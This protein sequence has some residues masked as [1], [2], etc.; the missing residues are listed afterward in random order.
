MG[1]RKKK[2]LIHG[3]AIMRGG[4][5]GPAPKDFFKSKFTAIKKEHFGVFLKPLKTLMQGK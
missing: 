4:G 2:S 1:R 3:H 5:K